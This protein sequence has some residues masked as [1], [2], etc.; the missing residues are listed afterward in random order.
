MLL[1]AFDCPA[2]WDKAGEVVKQ[3]VDYKLVTIPGAVVLFVLAYLFFYAAD[4]AEKT[5]KDA[6]MKE[7]ATRFAILSEAEA[8]S[9]TK[10]Q[11]YDQAKR[12]NISG[13]SRMN[14]SQLL[15][16]VNRKK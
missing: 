4:R 7:A 2:C 13:R 10:E 8:T 11:L 6:R 12:L 15:A 3:A 5:E 16:A 1:A 14:K 9:Q